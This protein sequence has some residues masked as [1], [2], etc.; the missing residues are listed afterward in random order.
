MVG[1]RLVR[2]IITGQS[3]RYAFI[4]YE[5]F[6]MA[7]DAYKYGRSLIINNTEIFVDFECGRTLPGW[8]PRRLGIKLSIVHVILW[9]MIYIV[10]NFCDKIIKC[11]NQILT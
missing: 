3:K 4:E 6:T 10:Y 2:D 1:L 11:L 9:N 7:L 8:K 5:T